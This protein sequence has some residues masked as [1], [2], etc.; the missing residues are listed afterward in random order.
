[1]CFPQTDNGE[2]LSPLEV[3]I[4]TTPANPVVNNPWSIN[5]L[6]NHP[7]P[8]EVEVRPPPFPSS[9]ALERFRSEA[10]FVQGERWTRVEY[11]FTPRRA[12]AFTLEPFEVLIHDRR[13][14]TREFFVRV[15]DEAQ[16]VTRYTPR[17]RWLLA[18]PSV[19]SGGKLDL[20]L[21]LTDWDPLE[22]APRFIFQGRAPEN[23]ILEESFP[24]NSDEKV[25]RY[26]ISVIALGESS[27]TL[28][29]FTGVSGNYVLNVPGIE[30]SVL[31]APALPPEAGN[32]RDAPDAADN[33][34]DE[35]FTA[36]PFPQSREIV[37]PL[38]REEYNRIITR[39]QNLW[40]NGS[41]ARALAEIR[42]YERDSFSGPYLAGLRKEMEQ[43]LGLNFTENEKWQP[44]KI[45]LVP[46][47]IIILVLLSAAFMLMVLLPPGSVTS[48]RRR[49]F[50]IIVIMVVSIGLAFIFLDDSLEN[51]PF[52]SLST[53]S[54]T[55]ILERT[56]VHRVPDFK[57]AVNTWFDEGQPVI[58]GDYHLG[59]CYAESP[60]G[61]A[62]WVRR[63]AVI[64]Y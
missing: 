53:S 33:S 41:R 15:R 45:P 21:E 19:F 55:A 13:A 14:L 23:A 7:N 59:W 30:I 48:R 40:E 63:E 52:G 17:F 20:L 46:H 1:V 56:E 4:E 37:F 28:E 38:F 49:G 27:I 24:V 32:F 22:D 60:D 10:R 29:P 58:V 54:N 39:V 6:V 44:L 43:A 16:T 51:F 61:R 35:E 18:A 5:V 26:T 9:L 31:P 62:G 50:K 2:S 8:Q 47:G 12:G 42:R 64:A 36:I 3:Q 25:I 57:G 11:L 34:G